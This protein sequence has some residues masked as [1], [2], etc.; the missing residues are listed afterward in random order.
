MVRWF[1][2]FKKLLIVLHSNI[3][4]EDCCRG[5]AIN[6]LG[7]GID[8]VNQKFLF[9]LNRLGTTNIKALAAINK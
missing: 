5:D 9:N 2:R 1:W 3:V 4:A 8:S 7:I 6:Y